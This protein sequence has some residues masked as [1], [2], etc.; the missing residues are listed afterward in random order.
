MLLT[1][2]VQGQDVMVV[3]EFVSTEQPEALVTSTAEVPLLVQPRKAQITRCGGHDSPPRTKLKLY[4]T[5]TLPVFLYGSYC[6]AISKTD[7]RRIDALDQ[8]CLR[9]LLAPNLSGIN[10][11]VRRLR[12]QPKPTAIIQRRRL[13][14][15]GQT[16]RMDDNADAKRILLASPPAS[17][18]LKKTTRSW[19]YR[20]PTDSS[21]TMD[22]LNC[23]YS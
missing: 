3:E 4:N 16:V 18:G 13:N 19:I 7:A 11:G 15:F 5:C 6:W 2:T 8:W 14:L 23:C 21:R 1:S 20:V 22:R 12:K 10:D 9:M 17:G